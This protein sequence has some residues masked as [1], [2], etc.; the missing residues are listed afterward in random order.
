MVESEEKV[1]VNEKRQIQSYFLCY[2]LINTIFSERADW[3]GGGQEI[4]A[5]SGHTSASG[6]CRPIVSPIEVHTEGS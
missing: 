2:Y 5:I 3:R 6:Q 4:A 1:S